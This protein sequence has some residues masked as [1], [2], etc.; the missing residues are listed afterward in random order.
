MTQEFTRRNDTRIAALAIEGRTAAEI[1]IAVV[2]SK[3]VAEKRLQALR[4]EGIIPDAVIGCPFSKNDD[5]VIIR[6]AAK[7]CSDAD[8]GAVINR[9]RRAVRG[10]RSILRTKHVAHPSKAVVRAPD[11]PWPADLYGK[12]PAPRG[13]SPA[14]TSISSR[15]V[16]GVPRAP[17][18]GW[19][20]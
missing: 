2:I 11:L 13:A 16:V 9:S 10:R 7:G 18:P 3:C 12:P 1:A 6:M 4:R 17:V 20:A 15:M 5:A 19:G 14:Y 8:I